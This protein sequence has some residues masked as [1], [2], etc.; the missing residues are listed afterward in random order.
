MVLEAFKEDKSEFLTENGFL[1]YDAC[2]KMSSSLLY[3]EY[4]ENLSVKGVTNVNKGFINSKCTTSDEILEA[5][6]KNVALEIICNY[7]ENGHGHVNDIL[8]G[9][10]EIYRDVLDALAEIGYDGCYNFEVSLK[11]IIESLIKETAEFEV[12]VMSDM[13]DTRYG[14]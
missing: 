10:K 3:K 7:K 8:F 13:L 12:K 6:E 14:K 1:A 5:F 9:Y 4:I 11:C 2:I